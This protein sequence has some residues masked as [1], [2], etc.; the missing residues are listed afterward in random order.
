MLRFSLYRSWLRRRGYRTF[1]G[2]VGQATIWLAV[3]GP[4]D[5]QER[6]AEVLP[7]CTEE[8]DGDA[9]RRLAFPKGDRPC[10]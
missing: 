2:G 1:R 3:R 4:G 8:R 5:A 6:A 9:A 10:S 7:D